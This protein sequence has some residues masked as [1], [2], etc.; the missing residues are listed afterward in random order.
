MAWLARLFA[1]LL[2]AA[3]ALGIGAWVLE[4][5]IG[6]GEYMKR[7]AH[8]T[9][10][11]E[12]LSGSLPAVLAADSAVPAQTQAALQQILTPAAVSAQLDTILPQLERYY[13][14]QGEQPQLQLQD[15]VAR[16]QATGVPIPP[17]VA[18]QL[19]ESQPV[20]AGELD[21]ALRSAAQQ[22]DQLHW[23]A[24]LAAAAL[25]GLILVLA[26]HR[27]WMILAGATFSAAISTLV[28]AG[29]AQLLPRIFVSTLDTSP[30]KPLTAPIRRYAEAIAADQ[31]HYL[32]WAAGVLGIITA[33]LVAV[34]FVLR[35]HYRFGHHLPKPGPRPG[36]PDGPPTSGM[37]R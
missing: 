37:S 9:Q 8:E 5:T 36:G 6:D 22:T 21:P 14:G 31:T 13:R 20:Q 34:H 17:E 10:L 12:G 30:A 35:M 3:L 26:R 29:V 33:V 24:P 19:S 11:A 25:V 28:M 4:R 16:A 18:A 1:G 32:L 23:V 2:A 15:L 27:R 7:Q